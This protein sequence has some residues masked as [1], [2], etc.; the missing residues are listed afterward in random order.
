MTS[1]RPAAVTAL[2]ATDAKNRPYA[3]AGNGV[4]QPA[5]VVASGITDGMQSI[6]NR[7]FEP[8]LLRL[9]QTLEFA[10]VNDLPA[11]VVGV[12][13]AKAQIYPGSTL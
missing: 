1:L 9:A 10:P 7:A 3:Q 5:Q 4:Q 8:A 12:H 11:R 6:A 2:L 13:A